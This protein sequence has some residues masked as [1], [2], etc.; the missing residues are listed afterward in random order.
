MA[1]GEHVSERRGRDLGCGGEQD[2]TGQQGTS[3]KE[4]RL[5]GWISTPSTD[6][7]L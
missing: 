4:G 7:E 6:C 2:S 3:C 1:A 5:W